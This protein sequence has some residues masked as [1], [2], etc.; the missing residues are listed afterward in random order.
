MTSRDYYARYVL[1]AYIQVQQRYPYPQLGTLSLPKRHS[2][3]FFSGGQLFAARSGRRLTLAA[4]DDQKQ[5]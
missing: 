3:D 2:V 1:V 4:I 5:E